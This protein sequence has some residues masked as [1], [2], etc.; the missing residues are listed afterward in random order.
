MLTVEHPLGHLPIQLEFAI[1]EYALAFL[2]RADEA[3]RLDA[4]RGADLN[5]LMLDRP[6][7]QLSTIGQCMVCGVGDL[8]TTL[9]LPARDH[10]RNHV[11]HVATCDLSNGPR[12]AIYHA[13]RGGPRM[14]ISAG[15]RPR[16]RAPRA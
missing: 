6:V 9:P 1:G 12:A 2:F 4:I 7:E 5:D 15:G 10:L 3:H 14:R 13:L 16:L 8:T 11:E